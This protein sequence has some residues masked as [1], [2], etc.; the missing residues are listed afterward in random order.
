MVKRKIKVNVDEAN[1]IKTLNEKIKNIKNED[2]I[3]E[4]DNTIKPAEKDIEPVTCI[5]EPETVSNTEPDSNPE[6]DNDEPDWKRWDN[7]ES[8]LQRRLKYDTYKDK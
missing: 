6:P 2:K 4:E 8:G 7:I 1:L 3:V 5:V